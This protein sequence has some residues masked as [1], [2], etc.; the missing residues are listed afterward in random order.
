M[1]DAADAEQNPMWGDFWRLAVLCG[2]RMGNMISMRWQDLDLS[3]ATWSLT[4]TKTEDY[5]IA[6]QPDAVAILK[7]RRKNRKGNC[8]YVFPS[9]DQPQEHMKQWRDSWKRIKKH[10]PELAD[11]T[12]HTL[13]RTY[14][15]LMTI[16]GVPLPTVGQQLG[17][18][19][20]SQ[21]TSIYARLDITA[22]REA[23]NTL[24]KLLKKKQ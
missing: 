8:Q 18:A 22:Q 23:A 4:H 5:T 2:A 14:G 20:G 12:P 13:R 21:A 7:R 10:V 19:P 9:K 17:H 24:G 16:A 6:L 15:S 1:F 11:T 3:N